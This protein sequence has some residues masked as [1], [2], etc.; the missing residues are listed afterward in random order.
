MCKSCLVARPSG[1]STG[2]APRVTYTPACTH[3]LQGLHAAVHVRV[4]VLVPAAL[5]RWR[6]GCGGLRWDVYCCVVVAVLT[7]LVYGGAC[8]QTT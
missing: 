5:R 3:A 6:M 4:M 8:R 2:E 7:N 1:Q